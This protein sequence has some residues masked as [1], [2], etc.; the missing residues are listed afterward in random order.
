MVFVYSSFEAIHLWM[1]QSIQE[2]NKWTL[3][4]T[5]FKKFKVIWS[6][7]ASITSNIFKGCLPQILFG[8]FLNILS[9][10]KVWLRNSSNKNLVW[11]QLL[12][13]SDI[14]FKAHRAC[15]QLYFS[16]PHENIWKPHAQPA[17]ACTKLTIETLKRGVTYMFKVN[18]KVTK[19]TP[20]SSF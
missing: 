7:S 2:W 20:M 3:W 12:S 16:I 14:N 6:A 10:M 13:H 19:T 8:P 1:K 18:N 15:F 5:T 17:I 9:H 4:K 11:K